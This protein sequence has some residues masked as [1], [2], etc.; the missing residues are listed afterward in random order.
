MFKIII[1]SVLILCSSVVLADTKDSMLYATFAEISIFPDKF[2]RKKVA[3]YGYLKNQNG[4][5]HLCESME[6]C[7]TESKNRFVVVGTTTEKT[8]LKEYLNCHVEFFGEFFKV[9]KSFA[10]DNR[11]ILGR[12]K[13]YRSPNL[14][15]NSGYL[16]INKRCDIYNKY[17]EK[18]GDIGVLN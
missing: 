10:Y 5:L 14:S 13:S 12:L 8:E 15:I 2:D 17:T 1:I 9:D 16:T 7:F 11:T 18:N 3:L 6:V 4:E